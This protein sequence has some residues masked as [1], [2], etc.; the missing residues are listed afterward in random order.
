M[1]CKF[2]CVSET[3]FPIEKNIKVLHD[4]LLTAYLITLNNYLG[5]KKLDFQLGKFLRESA[6]QLFYKFHVNRLIGCFVPYQSISPCLG[7]TK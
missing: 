1:F 5:A 2:V 4:I 6:Q 7:N 3:V